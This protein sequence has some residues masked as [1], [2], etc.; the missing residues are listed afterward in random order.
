VQVVL[1]DEDAV[2]IRQEGQREALALDQLRE[3]TPVRTH[4]RG[5]GGVRVATSIE[6]L[7]PAPGQTR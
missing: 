2:P 7:Q 4:F 3:G 6:V 5:E 1:K